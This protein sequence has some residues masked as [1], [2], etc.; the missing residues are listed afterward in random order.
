MRIRWWIF[1]YTFGFAMLS[2]VQRTSIGIA[3]ERIEPELHLS[4]MQIGWIM[5]SFTVMYTVMQAPAGAFG[6]RYGARLTYFIVGAVGCLAMIATPVAPMLLTGTAMFIALVVFQGILGVSQAPCFPVFAGVCEAWFPARQWGMANGINSSGMTLGTA[7]APPLIVLLTQRFGWQGALLWLSVPSL[8]LTL[9]WV[10]Y[11]RD[12]PREHRSVRPEEIAELGAGATE[13]RPRLTWE[14]FMALAVDR[15]V[16][17]LAVSYVCMNYLFYLLTNWCFLYLVQE[18]HLDAL[19]SGV[20]AMAPPVGAAVGSAVG[21]FMTDAFVARFGA[22]RGY[23]LVPLVFLPLAGLLLL[24][25]THVASAAAA[26]AGLTLAFFAT[27]ITEGPYWA[28]TMRAARADSMAATGVLNTGGNVGGVIGI[29][30]VAYLSGQQNWNA[31][32]AT[33][34]VFALVA[35]GLWLLVDPDRRHRADGTA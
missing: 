30:I 12:T 15:D 6:Q 35:A 24:L 28:A 29:P 4:Q 10:W 11:A 13:P 2:Y 31:A 26:V 27:E 17:A 8:L 19:Q 23:G 20:L 18:R 21:G 34:T 33:G 7:I 1:I 5:W 22:R 25:V 32:F 9:L 14:R 3:A 16:L